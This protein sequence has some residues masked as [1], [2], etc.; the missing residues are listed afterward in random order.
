MRGP[1]RLC[2]PPLLFLAVALACAPFRAAAASFP[3]PARGSS[4]KV[5]AAQRY[6]M[7]WDQGFELPPGSHLRFVKIGETGSDA[8]HLLRYRIFADAA[9]EGVPYVLGVWRIGADLEDLQV[10]SESAYVNRKGLVL[11][12]PPNPAQQDASELTDG[13]EAVVDIKAAKGEPVRFILRTQDSTTMIGGTLV[14]FPI[15]ATNKSCRL[16]ALL[17]DPGANA[18]LLYADG[19]PANSVLTMQSDSQGASHERTIYTDVK[20][21]GSAIDAPQVKGMEAGTATETIRARGC[22]VS[23]SV[24]WGAGSFHPM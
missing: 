3:D 17:A 4:E 19:F 18:V 15:E 5:P 9:Q 23:V 20:G 8:G 24:P 6:Q 10:L 22:T 13:S 1:L 16:R 12:N 7:L 14:P 21:H 11:N 2:A